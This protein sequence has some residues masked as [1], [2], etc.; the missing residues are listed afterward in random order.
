MLESAILNTS[1]RDR[2]YVIVTNY[3][4]RDFSH[5]RVL[6]AE[7]ESSQGSANE[8]VVQEPGSD[9]SGRSKE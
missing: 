8:E 6:S 1:G 3:Y 9:D 2:R 7:S 5:E 4:E